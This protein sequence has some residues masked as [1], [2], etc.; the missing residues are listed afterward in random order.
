MKSTLSNTQDR[1]F[2]RV[3]GVWYGIRART[4]ATIT[5]T[6][7]TLLSLDP[8]QKQGYLGLDESRHSQDREKVDQRK[9]DRRQGTRQLRLLEKKDCRTQ[10]RSNS[11]IL[12]LCNYM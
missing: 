2:Y 12:V 11:G 7:E 4:C 6:I 3:G 10:R 9:P 5:R 8:I 1:K